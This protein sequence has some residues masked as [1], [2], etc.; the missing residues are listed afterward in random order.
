MLEELAAWIKSGITQSILIDELE[1]QQV[2]IAVQEGG[3]STAV[4]W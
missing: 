3:T 4:Y 2:R 1:E